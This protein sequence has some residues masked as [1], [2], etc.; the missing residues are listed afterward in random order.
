MRYPVWAWASTFVLALAGLG[1]SLYL[2]IE[3]ATGSTSL[4]C[5]DAGLFNC[6]LVTTSTYSMVLGIPVAYLGLA[7]FVGAALLFSPWVW[8]L[9]AEPLRWVRLGAVTGGIAMVLYLLWAELYRIHGI[10][11][12]CTSVHVITLLLFAITLL[13]EAGGP[14]ERFEG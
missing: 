10:C 4:A 13:G 5:P 11:L 14:Q 8:R 3:H 1:V 2:S 6:H 9:Q 12:W 7:F